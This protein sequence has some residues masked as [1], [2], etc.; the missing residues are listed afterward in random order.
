MTMLDLDRVDLDDLCS[1]LEDNSPEHSSFLD[2]ATGE[3]HFRSEYFDSSEEWDADER[4]LVR[5]DPIGSSEAYGDM[6]DFVE[7]VTERR[8]R[9][10]LERAIAGRGAFRRFKDTLFEFPELREAWFQF[11]DARMRRRAIRWLRDEAL[12]SSDDADRAIAEI[13]E[14]AL[15]V[16]PRDAIVLAREVASD[17]KVLYGKRLKN[18]LL[19]G[20]WARGDAHPDSDIDLLVVLDEIEGRAREFARMDPILW[21]HSLA[22]DAVIT[23]VPVSEAEFQEPG[24]PLVARAKQE[25]IAV[26]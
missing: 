4:D 8:P 16:G 23:E 13:N 1:A 25:G 18:V 10:L 21:R 17:L 24:A 26:G 15:S 11:H 9:E 14:P 7:R 5:V 22:N 3:L 6:E 2:P 12:I 19:F 20:S